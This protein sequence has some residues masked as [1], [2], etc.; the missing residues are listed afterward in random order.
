MDVEY[1][2]ELHPTVLSKDLPRIDVVWKEI[3]R[4]TV[5][6]KLKTAPTHYGKP[7]RNKLRGYWKL[8]VGD[9]RVVYELRGKV[10]NIV[11]IFHRSI[12]YQILEKRL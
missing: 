3:I 9:Y 5:R 11:G 6:L 2:I 1:S 10:V 12:A 4:D 7:L 8:R